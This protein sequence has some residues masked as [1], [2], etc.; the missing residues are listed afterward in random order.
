MS[1]LIILVSATPRTLRHTEALLSER[2]HLVAALSSSHEANVLLDSVTPDLLVADVRE[3]EYADLH[4]A[5][6]SRVD[7]PDVPVIVT[8]GSADEIVEAEARRFGA[9]FL[10][11]PLDNPEFIPVVDAAIQ[12]R[13][14]EMPPVRRWFR[15]PAPWPVEVHAGDT[16]AR[17]VDVSYGGVRLA[18]ERP[19]DIPAT[20]EIA[21][22]PAGVSLRA[23]RVW[24]APAANGD[25]YWCGAA[26]V[27]GT[28][29]RWR[30][31]IDSLRDQIPS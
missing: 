5:I 6:R 24:M 11:S 17:I 4:I 3:G 28:D 20:F 22:P 14:R 30:R 27:D 16:R 26:L 13:R 7:H 19:A 31:F 1:A 21:I 10:E 2:G 15:A 23:Q 12:K 18:F 29:A 25:Q 8:S 9:A